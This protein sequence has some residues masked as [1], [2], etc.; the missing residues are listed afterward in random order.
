MKRIIGM[1]L[2]LV[3]AALMAQNHQ[4]LL[5]DSARMVVD[6]YVQMLDIDRLPQDSML[7]METAVTTHLDRKD[8]I[9]MRRWYA[10]GERHRIEVWDGKNLTYGVV[11]NGKD[12]FRYY[13]TAYESWDAINRQELEKKLQGYDFRGPL[14]RW[15]EKGAHLSW[16]GT[17]MLK[18]QPLQ[19]IKIDCPNMYTRYYMFEPESGLLTL[20]FETDELYDGTKEI[21]PGHIEWKSYHEFQP[22]RTGML[23]SLE[24]FMRDGVLT[25]MSTTYRF[26]AIDNNIFERD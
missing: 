5:S 14:Y 23:P 25:I 21:R 8:T 6:R 17:T 4:D 16:N 13:R 1:M 24:S 10:P 26:E 22:L 9:W 19:V 7:V 2:A 18:G 3:P 15:D 12:R 20:I 11:S